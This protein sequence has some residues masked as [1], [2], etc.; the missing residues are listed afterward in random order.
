MKQPDLYEAE[1]M[2]I[3]GTLHYRERT[4]VSKAFLALPAVA[5]VTWL[6]MVL[7]LG[8]PLLWVLPLVAFFL[9]FAVLQNL[10]LSVLRV[11]VSDE[12]LRVDRG[13]GGQRVELD[14]IESIQKT[15]LNPFYNN[16]LDWVGRR[17]RYYVPFKTTEGVEVTWR[18]EKGKPRTLLIG[19]T[20]PR[21][22]IA[23]IESARQRQRSQTHQRVALKA[24]DQVS[25]ALDDAAV[26]VEAAQ[27]ASVE[28]RR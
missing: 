16:S 10:L 2:E 9:L 6:V 1:H 25:L 27:E 21:Q 19:S 26:A 7:A 5:M 28:A 12:E 24:D 8:A 18:D 22:L 14:R 3:H 15:W 17:R 11:A 4:A 23:A 20:T 13:L